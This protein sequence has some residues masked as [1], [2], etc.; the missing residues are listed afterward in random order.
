MLFIKSEVA[1]LF[2]S[3]LSSKM[4]FIAL[5]ISVTLLLIFFVGKRVLLRL[6]P[7][8]FSLQVV[9]ALLCSAVALGQPCPCHIFT[10]QT[11]LDPLS[12][13]VPLELGVKFTSSI[14]G[15]ITGVRFYKTAGNTGAHVGELYSSTGTK[16]AS[17]TFSG[18][19][20]SGWQEVNFSTPVAVAANTTYIAAYF[21]PGGTYT[22]TANFFTADLVN[23]PLTGLGDGTDG[24]D[25]VFIFTSTPAFPNQSAGTK[26]NYWVDVTFSTTASPV[27]IAGPDQTIV[28]PTASVTLDGSGSTGAT[29]YSWT[30]LSGPNASTITSAATASTTVTGLI[31]GTYIYQLSVN[32]GASTSQVAVNVLPAGSSVTIFTTQFPTDPLA[33]DGKALELGVKFQS[34]QSGFIN[35][36]RFYKTTGNTGPHIGELYSATG[37]RM[38]SATFSGESVSGWQTVLFSAPVAIAANTTYIAAYFSPSGNY[39]GTVNYFTSA[40]VNSPL[41]GLADGTDG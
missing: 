9:I 39:T 35:G 2:T 27:A 7:F 6:I 8:R 22:G 25:G 34:S 20:P 21:S 14:A 17:A 5:A 38:A 12:T 40:V 41:T 31:A 11:P 19:T 29:S 18:E 36:V 23:A 30:Q 24:P 26:P 33:N 32:A 1:G 10:S 16:L 3:I 4:A 28:L 13:Q 15:F 37:T